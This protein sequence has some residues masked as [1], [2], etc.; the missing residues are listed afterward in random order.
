M[1]IL[2]DFEIDMCRRKVINFVKYVIWFFNVFQHSNV[3]LTFH[4]FFVFLC[5]RMLSC[6]L[7]SRVHVIKTEKKVKKKDG[8]SSDK[9]IEEKTE[10]TKKSEPS[11]ETKTQKDEKVPNSPKAKKVLD[12]ILIIVFMTSFTSLHEYC[13]VG[14]SFKGD[15]CIFKEASFHK[16]L[17]Y[18]FIY[19]R[20]ER[21]LGKL[22]RR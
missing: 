15:E 12:F 1:K 3:C 7:F 11:K 10:S 16:Y 9:K 17:I 20:K 21:R 8:S 6:A 5:K 19:F 18:L 2:I 4:D 13:C 14:E 22:K